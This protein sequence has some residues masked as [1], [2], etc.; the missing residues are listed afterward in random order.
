M[1]T[2]ETTRKGKPKGPGACP[3]W[4]LAHC[5]TASQGGSNGYQ[6][7]GFELTRSVCNLEP[8]DIE[9]EEWGARLAV[10]AERIDAQDDA[11]VLAWFDRNLPR[12]LA[13]V[14]H[15]RQQQFLR[16]V[17]QAVFEA[18]VDVTDR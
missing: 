1:K 2:L 13:L 9:E 6:A 11:G 14:P 7:A 16:G 4:F 10:L 12:C 3:T 17:Y 5:R 8:Y 15:R 18:E